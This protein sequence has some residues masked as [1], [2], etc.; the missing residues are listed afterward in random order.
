[1][2]KNNKGFTLLEMMLALG[3]IATLMLALTQLLSQ[4]ATTWNNSNKTIQAIENDEIA[5]NFIRK[6]LNRAKQTGW[7]S[8]DEISFVK[9]FIGQ[10]DQ[11]YFAAPLP[12][13]KA[14]QLGIYLF[15]F[16]VEKTEEYKNKSLVVSYWKLD[17]ESFEKT[18]ENKKYRDVIMTDVEQI[19]LSYFGDKEYNDG[20]DLPIWHSDWDAASGFPLAIKL[21]IKR[22]SANIN[23]LDDIPRTQWN[24]LTFTLLQRTQ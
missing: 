21:T 19:E 17:E 7:R 13:A 11:F 23:I 9:D 5:I 24:N 12:V 10:P 8:D 4:S 18:L 14:E 15:S 20:L 16:S 3:L 1:M 2:K 22:S 6:I